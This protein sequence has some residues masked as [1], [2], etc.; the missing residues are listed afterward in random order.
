MGPLSEKPKKATY[1]DSPW[2][3]TKTSMSC[4]TAGVE[5]RKGPCVREEI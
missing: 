5:D 4:I 1:W 3:A 2:D